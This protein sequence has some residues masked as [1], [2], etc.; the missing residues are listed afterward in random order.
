MS[1][2]LPRVGVIVVAYGR[3]DLLDE[4]LRT[5]VGSGHPP[6][7]VV[8]VDNSSDPLVAQAASRHG[9]AYVDPGA[10]LGFAGGVNRGLDEIERSSDV[11]LLNPDATVDRPTV[12]ELQRRLR[13]DSR[14]ACSAPAQVDG[15]GRAQRVRWPVPSPARAWLDVVR[16]GDRLPGATYLIGSVLLLRREALTDVG[17]FDDRFFLYAEEADWQRRAIDRGW[18][19]LLCEDLLASHVGAATSTDS[20]RRELLFAVGHERYM[21]KWH[22]SVGWHS[23]RAAQVV[24]GSLRVVLG[25]SA[26][27]RSAARRVATYAVGPLKAA[28]RP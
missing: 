17:R 19:T 25:A 24:G 18:C 1:P 9:S 2:S 28:S 8:V 5:I 26:G 13:S 6:L 11:L 21:R 12:D 23:Y 22:G 3:P 27:R 15:D 16:L 10:N 7:Q 14:I 4:T 20:R